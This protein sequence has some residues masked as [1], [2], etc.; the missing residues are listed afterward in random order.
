[1]N[2]FI[3]YLILTIIIECCFCIY[4]YNEYNKIH[5]VATFKY[6]LWYNGRYEEIIGLFI[7]WTVVVP[8]LLLLSGIIWLL[9]KV[10]I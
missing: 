2:Y 4:L 9:N 7:S 6:W 10:N 3:I 8:I 5:P 1:M